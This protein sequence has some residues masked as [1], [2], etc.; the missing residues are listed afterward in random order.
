MH[1]TEAQGMARQSGLRPP[2]SA[3]SQFSVALR[4]HCGAAE[5]RAY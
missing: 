3:H 1:L 4:P 2:D 5:N